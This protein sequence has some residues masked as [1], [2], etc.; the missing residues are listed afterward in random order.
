M[1]ARMS[2]LPSRST[3]SRA[4]RG[5]VLFIALIVIV[6]MALAGLALVRSV[7]TNVI[8][9]GNIAFKQ[10]A[11][12]AADQGI[13]AARTWLLNHKT[14][15]SDDQIILATDKY[16]SNWQ[17]N[18]D[19]TGNNPAKADFDWVNNS[20]EVTPDDGAGNRVR[21]VIHRLCAD[22][23]KTPSSTVCV[24]VSSTT[25]GALASGGEYGGRRGYEGGG[26][27]SAFNLATTTV[28]YRITVRVDGPRNTTSYVQ[29]LMY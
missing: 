13:E 14:T 12:N 26:S 28:Y 29:A 25:M 10:G 9:A 23:N 2:Q 22:S 8:A 21:Y 16:Y 4:Q 6:A 20:L 11:T 5:V 24:K 3:R 17:A 7:D 27:S 18:A 1:D 19:F 15:L